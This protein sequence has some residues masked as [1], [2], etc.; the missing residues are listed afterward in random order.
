MLKAYHDPV[1]KSL[2]R[3][4]DRAHPGAPK[5]IQMKSSKIEQND[6][7]ADEITQLMSAIGKFISP[8]VHRAALAAVDIGE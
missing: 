8:D 2:V 4:E 1:Q 6:C 5:Q 7:S 3:H